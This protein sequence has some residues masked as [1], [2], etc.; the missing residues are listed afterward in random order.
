MVV[1]GELIPTADTA[2]CSFHNADVL[3]MTG[4]QS[5][6]ATSV[7]RISLAPTAAAPMDVDSSSLNARRQP[8]YPQRTRPTPQHSIST[9]SIESCCSVSEG[10]A[11]IKAMLSNFEAGLN[12]V[13]AN[14]FEVPLSTTPQASVAYVPEN[15]LE[16]KEVK[17]APPPSWCSMCTRDITAPQNGQGAWYSCADCHVVVVSILSQ[18]FSNNSLLCLV[19]E[20]SRARK[21]RFL[22]ERY[23][24][25][26]HEIDV[27]PRRLPSHSLLAYALD[28]YQHERP[29]RRSTHNYS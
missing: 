23:G 28:K 3:G 18:I 19:Q 1:D 27:W 8:T 9:M 13:L 14:N 16:N 7:G 21:A 10:K 11:E 24:T 25:A 29:V 12:R 4:V 26:S 2:H 5:S 22:P 6:R 17:S 20:L 15:M